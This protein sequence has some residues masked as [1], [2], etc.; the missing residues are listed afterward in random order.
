MQVKTS[1]RGQALVLIALA[2]IGLIGI[3]ALVV[4][5]GNAFLDRR[6][7]QNAADSAAMASGLA[8]IRGENYVQRAFDS[9]AQNGYDNNGVTNSVQVFSPPVEGNHV[10]DIEY[11]QIILTSNVK[12]YFAGVIGRNTIVNR[13]SA[14]ARTKTPEVKELMDGY[15]VVSLAP[16]SDC[17]N[18]KSFWV[19][20]EATLDVDG[21]GVFV[22]SNNK[23]CALIVQGSGSIRIRT[24]DPISVVGGAL[25]QKP[26]LLT[27]YPPHT[28]TTPY[29]F[30]PPFFLPKVGCGGEAQIDEYTGTTMTAGKWYDDFPPEGVVNLGRG[31]YCI[32]DFILDDNTTLYGTGVT[33]VVKGEVHWNPHATLDLSA[34]KSGDNAGLLL[35]LPIDNHRR[36]VIN[37]GD[38]SA[39]SGTILAPGASI[40]LGGPN[41]QEGLHSQVIGYRIEVNGQSNIVIKYR[42][43]QNFDSFDMPELELSE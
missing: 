1:E 39:I 34:P 43:E 26:R 33:F 18:K 8:R 17:D 3:T 12:T 2:I 38:E 15:A 27:P 25:I 40:L 41:T 29:P 7:A 42:D 21:G 16:E 28:G 30:P 24:D 5:G 13:V 23:E 22:N 14:V 32:N 6:A 19:H 4:D 36:V 9:A 11:I 20:G 10:G 35:Y 31:V 37:A